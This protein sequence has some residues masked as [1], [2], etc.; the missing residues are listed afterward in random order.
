VSS[1]FFEEVEDLLVGF[2]PRA[3]RGFESR[4]SSINLKLWFGE[5]REHYEVQALRDGTLEVGFHTEHREEARNDEVL[6]RLLDGEQAWRKALGKEPEAGAFVG[7]RPRNWRRVSEVWELPG[8]L[9]P[10]AAWE[11]ADRLAAYVVAFE[12]LR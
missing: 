2:L 12:P 1:A 6:A 4:R 5:P 11:A 7:G 10:E 9:G 3:L 8:G